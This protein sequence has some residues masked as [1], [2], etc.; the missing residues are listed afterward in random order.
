VRR[1][2]GLVWTA[3]RWVLGNLPPA[4]VYTFRLP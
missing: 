1:A 4:R 2:L 3:S